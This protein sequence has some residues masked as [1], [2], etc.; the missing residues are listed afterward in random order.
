MPSRHAG[1]L[2]LSPNFVAGRFDVDIRSALKSQYH[3]SLKTLRLAIEKCPDSMWN[4]ANDGLAQFWRV[5]YH[6]IFY[7]HL[8]LQQE[9]K[10]FRPWAKAQPEANFIGNLSWENNRPPKD[11]KPY[12]PDEILEYW[13]LVDQ[14]VDP[15][16]DSLDLDSA[17]SGFFWYSMPKLEHQF[18]NIRHIQHHAAALATRLR[19]SNGVEIDWIASGRSEA[20]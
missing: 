4:D 16:I 19:R 13:E 14:M 3:A 2:S 20:V 11:C 9:E 7:T 15:A 18:V 6:A 17:N 1:K 10:T 5:S 8:Y 12:S